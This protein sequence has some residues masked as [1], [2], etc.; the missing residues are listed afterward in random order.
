MYTWAESMIESSGRI[1]IVDD[2]M[3]FA[4]SLALLLRDRGAD[5]IGVFSRG[6]EVP[7]F[8][9]REQPDLVVLDLG[10]PDIHGLVLGRQLLAAQPD[11]KLMALTGSSEPGVARAALSAGFHGFLSKQAPVE[12][13]VSGVA[14]ALTGGMVFIE[15]SHVVS[16]ID[17][18]KNRALTL[19]TRLTPRERHILGF[20]A[21]GASSKEIGRELHIS[22]NTVRT[23]VQNLTMKLHVNSRLGAVTFALRHGIVPDVESTAV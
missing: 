21:L 3:L 19:L 16:R 18:E 5:V 11:V 17:P 6:V 13:L 9:N 23:H 8:V 7:G 4:D 10:L 15:D 12:Q 14:A 1:V 22:V 2:H 20:L